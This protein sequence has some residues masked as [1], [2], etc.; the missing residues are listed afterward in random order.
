M[1]RA[2]SAPTPTLDVERELWAQ[3][4]RRLAGLD[5]A[6]R[7]AW[8]GPLVA[9]AVILPPM[10]AVPDELAGVRDSKQLSPAARSALDAAIRSIALGT[11]IGVVE[12]AELDL[13]GLS[14]AGWL[15]MRRALRALPVAPDYLL[16]DAFPLPGTDVPQRAVKFGDSLV[17]TIAAASIVAKVYRDRLLATLGELE[18]RYGFGAHKGYGTPEHQAAL[19]RHGPCFFHRRS[20]E[21]VRAVSVDE[22][23]PS[24]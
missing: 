12:P 11:G 18:P 6:G 8:A 16:I 3:G 14:A 7:G 13:L 10:D 9:A 1:G 4:Y 23:D 5:E 2:A 20:Y 22:R 17:F 21:P 15:A 24:R 19:H